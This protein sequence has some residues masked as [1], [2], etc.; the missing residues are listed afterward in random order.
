QMSVNFRTVWSDASAQ[1]ARLAS[2]NAE[3]FWKAAWGVLSR[4]ND[5][6]RLIEP[7]LTPS[8][9]KLL[10]TRQ[11]QWEEQGTVAT[12]PKVDGHVLECP[13]VARFDSVY[14][15]DL[16]L[17]DQSSH[18]TICGLQYLM[19][20]AGGQDLE[21]IDY[22]NVQR[23]LLK[24]IADCGAT[25][26]E[27]HSRPVV[28]SF[29]A[30]VR[31]DLDWTSAL[32]RK[33][34]M[35]DDVDL[36]GV[37]ASEFCGLLTDKGRKQ[38]QALLELWLGVFAKMRS[39]RS[40]YKWSTLYDLFTRMLSRGDN[41]VQRR[42]LDCLLVWRESEITPYADNLRNLLDEKRF[43]DELGTFDLATTGESINVVHRAKLLPVVFRILH[44][45]TLVR[46]GKASRK[47][48]MK[49]RRAA[50]LSA[51]AAVSADE[52][53]LFVSIGLESFRAVLAS[54]TPEE[55]I[56]G[57]SAEPFCFGYR[58]D[59]MD[60]D[61]EEEGNV[62]EAMV[63]AAGGLAIEKVSSK[64]QI[65]F[66]HLLSEMVRQLGFKTTPVIHEALVIL[67]SAIEN[68]ERQ[69][70]AANVEIQ[71]MIAAGR[72]SGCLVDQDEDEGDDQ[73]G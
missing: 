71:K 57:S 67:L 41:A 7:G 55:M 48:G 60:V 4:Y 23:Q 14:D 8:A 59:D 25:I 10:K 42:A 69:I 64:A 56:H 26:A 40:L 47:D 65:S 21:R 68:A 44:G 45:Q 58:A 6:R 72:E 9:K 51:M 46:S 24:L 36:T 19:I 17:F 49:I 43:R 38:K 31:Y 27:K 15:S 22:T 73:D 37:R 30:F 34:L 35:N 70:D 2:A 53:R 5:E 66:F 16:Q 63:D 54:A 28:R 11:E 62:D 61:G 33:G 20:G 12:Q 18:S 3:L 39:P 32:Y 13:N 52:L 50:V 29:L 1:L